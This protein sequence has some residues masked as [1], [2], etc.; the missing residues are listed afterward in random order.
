VSNYYE[1]WASVGDKAGQIV[2]RTVWKQWSLLGS[3][4]GTTRDEAETMVIDPEALIVASIILRADERRLEEVL[5]WWACEGTQLLSILRVK[6]VSK[7]IG[8]NDNEVLSSY[9][10]VAK[11]FGHRSWKK[12]ASVDSSVWGTTYNRS[13]N[14]LRLRGPSNLILRLR[15]ALGV[16][17]KPDIL[18][19]LI[20]MSNDFASVTE[21]SRTL[22]YTPTAVRDALKDMTMAGLVSESTGRPAGY[23]TNRIAWAQV[24]LTNGRNGDNLPQWCMWAAFFPFLLLVRAISSRVVSGDMND[25]LANSHVRDHV[26]RFSFAFDYHKIIIPD[27]SDYPGLSYSVAVSEL[28]KSLEE[29]LNQRPDAAD[30]SPG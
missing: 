19:Y 22:G 18:S 20:S 2:L 21:I 1:N 23:A 28:L 11:R 29:G 14:R 10:T 15:A 12:Y 24:L 26:E 16:G 6:R 25:Y 9:A 5:G 30:Q 27:G 13:S 4:V 8:E 3:M 7:L 17:A